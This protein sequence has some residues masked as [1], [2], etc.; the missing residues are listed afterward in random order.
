MV[1]IRTRETYIGMLVSLLWVAIV[2]SSAHADAGFL[3]SRMKPEQVFEMTLLW[4]NGTSYRQY[5]TV[6]DN[7]RICEI[8][9]SGDAERCR[10]NLIP[11][12]QAFKQIPVVEFVPRLPE[13]IHRGAEADT[14]VVLAAIF[15]EW[16]AAD[17]HASQWQL[18]C[19]VMPDDET[20]AVCL[21][22]DR[23]DHFNYVIVQAE[24]LMCLIAR[25][26]S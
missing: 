9:A 10:I 4:D 6:D 23:I 25:L 18:A 13:S 24:P 1:M 26:T 12:A 7:Q 5:A 3:L 20:L 2:V 17:Q 21:Q 15:K 16:D 8:A 22:V 11:I 14:P 19:S